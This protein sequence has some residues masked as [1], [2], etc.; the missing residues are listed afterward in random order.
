MVNLP[1]AALANLAVVA[2]QDLL[3]AIEAAPARAA[4]RPLNIV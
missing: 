4:M 3:V 1:R 2:E